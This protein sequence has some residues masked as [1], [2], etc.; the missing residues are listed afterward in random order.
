MN[1]RVVLSNF[2]I[3]PE[4]VSLKQFY[5]VKI[6][7]VSVSG[8]IFVQIL[9][10]KSIYFLAIIFFSFVLSSCSADHITGKWELMNIDYSDYLKN[11]QPEVRNLLEPALK[12]QFESMKGKTFFTL[13][14]D[15]SLVLETPAFGGEIT[16]VDGKWE[17]SKEKDSL[18]FLLNEDEHYLILK[19]DKDNMVL[20]T[21]EVPGRTLILAR[22]K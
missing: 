2:I 20:K 16:K 3:L 14:K 6:C 21:D 10:M 7:P 15:H 12:R 17:Y 19:S 11:A 4:M 5:F 1:E 9:K 18:Y 22:K 8:S 13:E